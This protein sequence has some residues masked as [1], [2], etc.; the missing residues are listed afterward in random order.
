VCVCLFVCLFSFLNWIIVLFCLLLSIVQ[1]A[2]RS[3][4]WR[5][6]AAL[7]S[8]HMIQL[9]PVIVTEPCSSVL[10]WMATD[11]RARNSI[12]VTYEKNLYIAAVC[13]WVSGCWVTPC[14][15]TLRTWFFAAF[16]TRH[17]EKHMELEAVYCSAF[18]SAWWQQQCSEAGACSSGCRWPDLAN[19]VFLL[20]WA[21]WPTLRVCEFGQ[22]TYSGHKKVFSVLLN[23]LPC[24]CCHCCS[25][26]Y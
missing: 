24:N 20:W 26:G 14:C 22:E 15:H 17:Q 4:N 2:R 18:N 3:L 25:R 23:Y 7:V 10:K 1:E 6:H 8:I 9:P 5:Q 19:A 11:E 12:S 13:D 16:L 21:V